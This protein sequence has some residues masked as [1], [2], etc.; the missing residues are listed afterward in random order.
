MLFRWFSDLA[1]SFSV[2]DIEKFGS[3][4]TEH[5]GQVKSFLL[6]LFIYSFIFFFFGGG[7]EKK[8]VCL[9][10]LFKQQLETH[11]QENQQ[12]LQLDLSVRTKARLP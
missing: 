12:G 4:S 2:Q 7:G 6:L 9:W 11:L 1:I 10:T 3:L 8:I 5:C